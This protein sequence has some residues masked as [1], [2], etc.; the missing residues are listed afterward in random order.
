MGH[1][2]EALEQEGKTIP[3]GLSK[4]G[5]PTNWQTCRWTMAVLGG[6][7]QNRCWKVPS[8]RTC[9]SLACKTSTL[10]TYKSRLN[11]LGR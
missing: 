4:Q 11:K 10:Q 8:K 6:V 2:E 1:N 5:I 9:L 7:Q 3:E